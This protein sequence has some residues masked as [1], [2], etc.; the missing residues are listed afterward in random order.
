MNRWPYEADCVLWEI[1]GLVVVS[2][3]ISDVARLTSNFWSCDYLIWIGGF[4]IFG[5]TLGDSF[6]SNFICVVDLGV[7]EVYFW[8]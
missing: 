3:P 4:F 5:N 1:T 6:G 7:A 8:G 2:L